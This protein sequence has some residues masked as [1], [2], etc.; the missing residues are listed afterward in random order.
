MINL[1]KFY[2]F[3][4]KHNDN[5][6]RQLEFIRELNAISLEKA[7]SRSS[8]YPFDEGFGRLGIQ[9]YINAGAK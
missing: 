6:A 8:D 4:Q 7:P 9:Y 5:D 1:I 2:Y 3:W